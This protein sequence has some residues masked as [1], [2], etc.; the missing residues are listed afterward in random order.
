[1]RR[2]WGR[3]QHLDDAAGVA[4]KNRE[5]PPGIA[6]IQP[7]TYNM[8]RDWSA[9]LQTLAQTCEWP[10]LQPH[11][12]RSRPRAATVSALQSAPRNTLIYPQATPFRP[13]R[14]P[15]HH[16]QP[17]TPVLALTTHRATV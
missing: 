17:C 7:H 2:G 4:V 15:E 13:L 10:A 9:R 5:T 16:V 6:K 12:T 14:E 1:M 11:T 3:W 8:P